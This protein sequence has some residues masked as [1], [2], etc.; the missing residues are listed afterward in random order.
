MAAPGCYAT[1][2]ILALAP[3]LAADL[4]EASDVV[5]VAASGTSGA[6]RSLRPDLLGSEVM[7]SMSAYQVGGTHRHTPEIEQVLLTERS[8]VPRSGQVTLS[9]TPTLA[10]MARGI[11]ATCTARSAAC[12]RSTS[13]RTTGYV[14]ASGFSVKSGL[15]TLATAAM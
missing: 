6:G 14:G 8:V 12:T 4:V 11:L 13:S 1:A 15:P 3:L 2:C 9:F 5:I 10:P 7:G